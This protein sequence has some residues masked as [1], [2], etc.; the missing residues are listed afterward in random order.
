MTRG[1]VTDLLSQEFLSGRVGDRR[2]V[3]HSALCFW[4]TVTIP[5]FHGSPLLGIPVATSMI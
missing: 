1:R 3:F 2:C 4:S 5:H